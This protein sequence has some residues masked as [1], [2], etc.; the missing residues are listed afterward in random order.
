MPAQGCVWRR[1]SWRRR[2]WR[3][4]VQVC[5][6]VVCGGRGLRWL[7]WAAC[8]RAPAVPGQQHGNCPSLTPCSRLPQP[9][10]PRPRTREAS[11]L[12]IKSKNWPRRIGLRGGGPKMMDGRRM[13]WRRQ[14]AATA[15]SPS[16]LLLWKA[17]GGRAG[18]GAATSQAWKQ[19]GQ[20]TEEQGSAAP[21]V[22]W[23]MSAVARCPHPL[24]P[25]SPPLVPRA[26]LLPLSPGN[27]AC[28]TRSLAPGGRPLCRRSGCRR[29]RGLWRCGPE[30]ARCTTCAGRGAEWSDWEVQRAERKGARAATA[31][32]GGSHLQ[33]S[34][35]KGR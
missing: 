27:L 22:G 34:R 2:S 8:A 5:V 7:A 11:E 9:S 24:K 28:R 30:R 16:T 29:T 14:R 10:A 13:T 31:A 3:R 18:R 12:S 6:C 15:A 4:V 33:P 19:P 25:A 21:P 23:Q 1:R 26:P 35:Q 32:H 17:V 20:G